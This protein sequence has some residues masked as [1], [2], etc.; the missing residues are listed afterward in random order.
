M[1]SGHERE[2]HTGKKKKKAFKLGK[3]AAGTS[4][5]HYYIARHE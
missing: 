4:F 3:L 5:Y 1:C 2:T